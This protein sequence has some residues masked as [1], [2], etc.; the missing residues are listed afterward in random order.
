M[1][2]IFAAILGVC[3]TVAVAAPTAHAQKSQDTLRMA[4]TDWWSTLDPYHFPLD[5]AAV[6]YRTIYE[7]PVAYDERTKQFVPRVAKSWKRID[8]RTL[9]FELRDDVKFS[10]G[11][12][13]RPPTTCCTPSPISATRM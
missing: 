3:A 1:A 9:E 6:F 2:K 8:D 11:D 10:N 7:T 5:E 4:V 13:A 12:Q